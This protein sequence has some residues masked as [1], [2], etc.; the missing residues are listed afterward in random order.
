M[1]KTTLPMPQIEPTGD[2]IGGRPRF[3]L[4]HPFSLTVPMGDS[5]TYHFRIP[6]GFE[7]DFASV[8]RLLWWFVHP[9][10]PHILVGSLIHDD[11]YTLRKSTVTLQTG[12]GREHTESLVLSRWMCDSWLRF[13]MSMFGAPLWKQVLAFWVVRLGGRRHYRRTI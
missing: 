1:A 9:M 12:A 7:T 4:A 2:T 3:R 10:D 13:I 8:P 5:G 6:A 11:L